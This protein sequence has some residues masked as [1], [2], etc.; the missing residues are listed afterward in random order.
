M[1]ALGRSAAVQSAQADFVT[2]ELR[3]NRLDGSAHDALNSARAGPV[4]AICGIAGACGPA[5]SPAL[6]R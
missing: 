4:P 6:I 2:C 1:S 5:D 3:F